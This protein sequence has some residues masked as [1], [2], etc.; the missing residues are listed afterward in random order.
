MH[1]NFKVEPGSEQD[2]HRTV[3]KVKH[4]TYNPENRFLQ[5]KNGLDEAGRINTGPENYAFS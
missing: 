5:W 3:L 4:C 2:R 1:K